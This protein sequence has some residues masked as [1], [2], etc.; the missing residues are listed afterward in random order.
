[1]EWAQGL[2]MQLLRKRERKQKVKDKDNA[3]PPCGGIASS[4]GSWCMTSGIVAERNQQSIDSR[5]TDD[6]QNIV[7]KSCCIAWTVRI[8]RSKIVK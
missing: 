7:L 2:L 1:M 6:A 8:L 3:V 5:V 4:T